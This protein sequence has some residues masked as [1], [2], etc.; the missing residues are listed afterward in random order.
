MFPEYKGL[1]NTLS[2]SEDADELEKSWLK[3]R[4]KPRLFVRCSIMY[5][6]AALCSRNWRKEN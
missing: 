4:I 1:T 2:N 3:F 5:E 6:K